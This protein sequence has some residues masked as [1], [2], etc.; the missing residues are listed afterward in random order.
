MK[1]KEEITVYNRSLRVELKIVENSLI[2]FKEGLD[3]IYSI[4][5][6]DLKVHTDLKCEIIAFLVW[7]E[8]Q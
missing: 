4:F 5:V 3:H 1:D 7:N 6:R 2:C 8:T